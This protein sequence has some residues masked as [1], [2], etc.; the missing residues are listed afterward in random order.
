M[1][2]K[3]FWVRG[4][5]VCAAL[6]EHRG[7][8]VFSGDHS[9]GWV[10]FPA[11]QLMNSV[12]LDKLL[13]TPCPPVCM[14]TLI[15]QVGINQCL[16]SNLRSLMKSTVQE[17]NVRRHRSVLEIVITPISFPELKGR[18]VRGFLKQGETFLCGF[19]C[20]TKH[21][22]P[23]DPRCV[24]LACVD[25]CF[26]LSLLENDCAGSRDLFERLWPKFLH[27]HRPLQCLINKPWKQT[28]LHLLLEATAGKELSGKA[29]DQHSYLK[30][31]GQI[32]VHR[33][34]VNTVWSNRC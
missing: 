7:V 10:W 26:Q 25:L 27:N 31:R 11:P 6:Q 19:L 34:I 9:Q 13:N 14:R 30:T 29:G 17:E 12:S 18:G 15:S 3:V 28:N 33:E 22:L 23:L 1:F 8:E 16:K 20:S 24:Y 5:R 21:Q 4:W 32:L 2:L